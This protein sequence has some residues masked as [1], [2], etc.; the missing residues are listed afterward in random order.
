M[1]VP[2]V[3]GVTE[4]DANKVRDRLK[5]AGLSCRITQKR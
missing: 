4:E 2:V 3:K 1:I 5:D